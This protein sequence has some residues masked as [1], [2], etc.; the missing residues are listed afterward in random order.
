MPGKSIVDYFIGRLTLA[1]LNPSNPFLEELQFHAD[2]NV[3]Y[4]RSGLID[5]SGANHKAETIFKIFELLDKVNTELSQNGHDVLHKRNAIIFVERLLIDVVKRNYQISPPSQSDPI[6][7]NYGTHRLRSSL[8]SMSVDQYFYLCGRH[9]DVSDDDWKLEHLEYFFNVVCSIMSHNFPLCEYLVLSLANPQNNTAPSYL[10]DKE[11]EVIDNLSGCLL[12][13]VAF[14]SPLE[15]FDSLSRRLTTPVATADRNNNNNNNNTTNSSSPLSA[16]LSTDPV[17]ISQLELFLKYAQMFEYIFLGNDL[18]SSNA[19]ICKGFEFVATLFETSDLD[20]PK[21]QLVFINFMRAIKHWIAH[22][23]SN[24]LALATGEHSQICDRAKL[25]FYHMVPYLRNNDINFSSPHNNN[26]EDLADTGNPDRFALYN[27]RT[28]ARAMGTLLCLNPTAFDKFNRMC[29]QET[30]SNEELENDYQLKYLYTITSHISAGTSDP[31]YIDNCDSF[32]LICGVA[33]AIVKYQQTHPIVNFS[34]NYHQ[35]VLETLQIGKTN[36]Y[37]FDNMPLKVDFTKENYVFSKYN[38]EAVDELR[39]CFFCFQSAL[40]PSAFFAFINYVLNIENP[41]SLHRLLV[42]LCGLRLYYEVSLSKNN[43]YNNDIKGFMLEFMLKFVHIINGSRNLSASETT[44]QLTAS[45][46]NFANPNTTGFHNLK[47]NLREE[48]VPA[49]PPRPPQSNTKNSN[50]SGGGLKTLNSP[51]VVHS[52]RISRENSPAPPNSNNDRSSSLTKHGTRHAYTP[53][54]RRNNNNY[55]NNNSNNNSSSNSNN[56]TFNSI[57]HAGSITDESESLSRSNKLYDDT[58]NLAKAFFKHDKRDKLRFYNGEFKKKYGGSGSH[59]STTYSDSATTSGALTTSAPSAGPSASTT[60]TPTPNPTN[61]NFK[62]PRIS[63]D[64]ENSNNNV[65]SNSNSGSSNNTSYCNAPT[66]SGTPIAL[67]TSKPLTPSALS[68]SLLSPSVSSPNV[69]TPLAATAA[70]NDS[71]FF[72]NIDLNGVKPYN[73]LNYQINLLDPVATSKRLLSNLFTIIRMSPCS[74]I[75]TNIV[76]DNLFINEIL[77]DSSSPISDELY[78][79]FHLFDAIACGLEDEDGELI[80][81]S[82]HLLIK[83]LDIRIFRDLED[84][85]SIAEKLPDAIDFSNGTMYQMMKRFELGNPRLPGLLEIFSEVLQERLLLLK[86]KYPLIVLSATNHFKE[87][88]FVRK[89]LRRLEEF[90]FFMSCSPNV[91]VYQY[92]TKILHIVEQEMNLFGYGSEADSLNELDG[93]KNKEFFQGLLADKHSITGLVAFRKKVRNLLLKHILYPTESLVNVWLIL[94]S[95]WEYYKPQI[96]EDN[97]ENIKTYEGITRFLAMTCGILLNG[98]EQAP[99]QLE[100]HITTFIQA[101]IDLLKSSNITIQMLVKSIITEELHPKAYKL[102]ARRLLQFGKDYYS[103]HYAEAS[104]SN[105]FNVADTILTFIRNVYLTKDKILIFELSLAIAC[106]VQVVLLMVENTNCIQ[107]Y[108]IKIKMCKICSESLTNST[109]E[110]RGSL[111]LRN[112][113]TKTVMNWLKECTMCNEDKGSPPFYNN[114]A[115]SE[116]VPND[117]RSSH[118]DVNYNNSNN[119][120]ASNRNNSESIRSSA[121]STLESIK[122]AHSSDKYSLVDTSEPTLP[123]KFR[124]AAEEDIT[125]NDSN[126]DSGKKSKFHAHKYYHQHRGFSDIKLN[127]CYEAAKALEALTLGL[128]LAP[129]TAVYRDDLIKQKESMIENY[130]L[131]IFATLNHYA[132]IDKSVNFV[133]AQRVEESFDHLVVGL[134]NLFVANIDIALEK[135]ISL[136]FHHDVRLRMIFLKIFINIIRSS[137]SHIAPTLQTRKDLEEKFLKIIIDNIDFA[138]A[139]AQVCP[140]SEVD[141][142]ACALLNAYE[143]QGKALHIIIKL[144]EY[145]MKTAIHASTVL[146]QNTVAT[147][148]LYLFTKSAAGNSYLSLVLQPVLKQI[149]ARKA[150]FDFDNEVIESSETS[151]S[152]EEVE[153]NVALFLNYLS[154]IVDCIVGSVEYFPA[155]FKIICS[156]IR[157]EYTKQ[158]T[159]RDPLGVVNAFVFL[160]FICPA[161]V[162]PDTNLSIKRD[163]NKEERKSFVLLARVLQTLANGSTVNAKWP[164]LAHK[165]DVLDSMSFKIMHFLDEISSFPVDDL[166]QAEKV[167]HDSNEFLYLHKFVFEN[168]LDIRDALLKLRISS[169]ASI[170][171]KYALCKKLDSILNGLGPPTLTKEYQIPEEIK[172]GAEQN[173]KLYDFMSKFSMIDSSSIVGIPF[174][175]REKSEDGYSMIIFSYYYYQKHKIDPILAVYVMLQAM[176]ENLNQKYYCVIDVTEYSDTYKAFPTDFMLPLITEDMLNSLIGVYYVNVSTNFLRRVSAAYDKGKSLFFFK[177]NINGVDCVSTFQDPEFAIKTHLTKHTLSIANEKKY[178]FNDV[179]VYVEEIKTYLPGSLTIGSKYIQLALNEAHSNLVKKGEKPIEILD[180]YHLKSAQISLPSTKTSGNEFLL[181][182]T[183]TGAKTMLQ[184]PKRLNIMKMF[185]V[186]KSKLSEKHWKIESKKS[187]MKSK[188]EID[189]YLG[190]LLN[191]TLAGILSQDENIRT[192]SSNLL[193]LLVKKFQFDLNYHITYNEDQPVPE[194]N[195]W[196]VVQVSRILAKQ[197]PDLTFKMINGFFHVFNTSNEPKK[198]FMIYISPWIE[199]LY[200]Y[201]YCSADPQGITKTMNIIREFI[202]LTQEEQHFSL[203]KVFIWTKLMANDELIDVILTEVVNLAVEYETLH[204]SWSKIITIITSTSTLTICSCILRRLIKLSRKL[205]KLDSVENHIL[206]AEITVLVKMCSYSFFNSKYHFE[207]YF[208]ELLFVVSIYS[209]VGPKSLRKDLYGLTYSLFRTFKGDGNSQ[210]ANELINYL[211]S[212][213]AKLIYGLYNADEGH[214]A[215]DRRQISGIVTRYA[216]LIKKFLSFINNYP[217]RHLRDLWKTRWSGYTYD[218]VFLGKGFLQS[219]A[220]LLFGVLASERISESL[221]FR[222]LKKSGSYALEERDG[223]LLFSENSVNNVYALSMCVEGLTFNLRLLFFSVWIGGCRCL[224]D[225]IIMYEAALKFFGKVAD[226][227]NKKFEFRSSKEENQRIMFEGRIPGGDTL[228]MYEKFCGFEIDSENYDIFLCFLFA[229]GMHVPFLKN[230]VIRTLTTVMNVKKNMVQNSNGQYYS[231][232]MCFLFIL[233]N[234]R[235]FWQTLVE[236]GIDTTKVTEL[237]HD[238]KIPKCIADDLTDDCLHTLAMLVILSY[239]FNSRTIEENEKIKIMLLMKYIAEK[240][241]IIMVKFFKKYIDMIEVAQKN[242]MS[243]TVLA[244]AVDIFKLIS[245]SGVVVSKEISASYLDSVLEKIGCIGIKNYRFVNY[246]ES[247]DKRLTPEEIEENNMIFMRQQRMLNNILTLCV[248]HFTSY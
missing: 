11:V 118:H 190:D 41:K 151:G 87:V 101:H 68:P 123:S 239:Y 200:S 154:M 201:V 84:D 1:L 74:F 64:N 166:P 153:Q 212:D 209:N 194:D 45:T 32:I 218:L 91:E 76:A 90:F 164:L 242:E 159:D 2:P 145:E 245:M 54:I 110:V 97:Y 98:L 116:F 182:N 57:T 152:S 56:S 237:D 221:L 24:Y 52:R 142:L 104:T 4:L 9:S 230:D 72:E 44:S 191:L 47:P 234:K 220:L 181:I 207:E 189:S 224:T 137:T 36:Y 55:N 26:V 109:L 167:Y 18:T 235:D 13:F 102:V 146:R 183:D 126:Q 165:Q 61:E 12:T 129:L 196:Q 176:L 195:I 202:R 66:A 28:F 205:E 71:P 149:I 89:Q 213:T 38:A 67:S 15:Y 233:K 228:A 210:E 135:S 143:S 33:S 3:A 222:L 20:G 122:T 139:L 133:R 117:S 162:N 168:F 108:Q 134:G 7:S 99:K 192:S 223:K 8:S 31:S 247:N 60:A 58:K 35:I 25:L 22:N 170:E 215:K 127:L 65:Y 16:K 5:I 177:P 29:S 132:G 73:N 43:E 27:K 119:N 114:D 178:V 77:H 172:N 42:L 17:A 243:L 53:A 217:D 188:N 88:H 208:P 14:L 147:R 173:S 94:N 246:N 96:F 112:F 216:T 131:I 160:R 148:L 175:K 69:S 124:S 63:L 21:K 39:I 105:R 229:R 62:S 81:S 59:S 82:R 51:A 158:F 30:I 226:T 163:F 49:K 206:L 85:A 79:L 10:P 19:L 232:Y 107:S 174:I 155:S 103:H 231:S 241:V 198:L 199:N 125:A 184:S 86:A 83:L 227:I 113:Y 93:W 236:S 120:D 161:L 214:I 238:V 50:R 144:V 130:F 40:D 244:I 187:N 70:L 92:L 48:S 185:H 23:Q 6:V 75:D 193:L 140:S 106:L 197:R 95:K 179:D 157:Q 240:N 128:S 156:A 211:E 203:L 171:L 169:D 34:Q 219:K 136:G 225:D 141:F 121:E 186:T 46:V 78:T 138:V 204:K 180:V 248:D 111:W 80:N 150:Y 100:E 115:S 37:D